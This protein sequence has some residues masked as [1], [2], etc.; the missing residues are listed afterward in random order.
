MKKIKHHTSTIQQHL[1]SLSAAIRQQQR[2]DGY[3]RDG[4]NN[5]N[6]D[7]RDDN[8]DPRVNKTI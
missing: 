3:L 6:D 1:F 8:D 4:D 7:P 2:S 5:D